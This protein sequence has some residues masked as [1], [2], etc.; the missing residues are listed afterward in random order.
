M[1]PEF[2]VVEDADR[3]FGFIEEAPKFEHNIPLEQLLLVKDLV[4]QEKWK[5][6]NII[7]QKLDWLIKHRVAD[8][9][10]CYHLETEIIRGKQ[11]RKYVWSR[12]AILVG[13]CVAFLEFIVHIAPILAA[14]L[15][16]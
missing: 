15:F 2:E 5:L 12:V 13:L 14:R 8:N 4:V 10:N 1:T 6:D 3:R 9:N 7:G 11:F 16:N